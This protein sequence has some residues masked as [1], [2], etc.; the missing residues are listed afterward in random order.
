MHT[1]TDIPVSLDTEALM[2]KLKIEAGSEDAAR[3]SDLVAHAEQIARPKTVYREAFIE[4]TDTDSVLV[5]G[6]SF[7]SRALSRNVAG[8]GRL[9]AFVVTCGRE[10]HE[11]APDDGDFITE[12]WWDAIKERI[13]RIA[14]CRLFE[15]LEET[16]HLGRTASMSP[17]SADA[18]VWPIEQQRE[19]FHLIGG[20]ERVYEATGV[21]LTDS[22][23]MVPNKSVSGVRF[24]T[25][26]RFE[27]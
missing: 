17:G 11:N 4:E 21:E 14:C 22:C 27:S 5:D 20:T 23:L 3:F 7:R 2:R 15:H 19:L 13:L 6:V 16:F 1:I 25:E 8:A 9:F 24:P 10:V 18:M 26:I 12:Y